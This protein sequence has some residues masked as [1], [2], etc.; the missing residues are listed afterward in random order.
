M[1]IDAL[2]DKQRQLL[3]V[4][5]LAL[6]IFTII[7]LTIVPL[8]AMN[9]HYANNIDELDNRL[10]ILQRAVSASDGLR[11]QHE[12]LKRSLAGNRHYLQ[13]NSDALAAANLQSTVKRL[14]SARSMEVLSTQIL[15][16]KEEA[17]FTRVALKVRMRGTLDNTVQLMH[18]LETGQPYLFLD[19]VTIRSYSRRR[20]GNA[21]G[22]LLNVD[23]DLIGYM[24]PQ[25]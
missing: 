3:A 11:T 6:V 16:S 9:R 21:A 4:A 15:P 12:Q 20:A 19:N 17:G 23:F 10:Q 2:S 25:S 14:A 22:Q 13:G 7:M 18:G 5:I 8:W 24:L 1:M